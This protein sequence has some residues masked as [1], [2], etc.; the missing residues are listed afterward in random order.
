MFTYAFFSFSNA[1]RHTYRSRSRPTSDNEQ[2]EEEEEDE[3]DNGPVDPKVQKEID[4]LSKIPE[5]GVGK[6]G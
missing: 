2:E 4:E 5:S 6:V 1:V 3:T